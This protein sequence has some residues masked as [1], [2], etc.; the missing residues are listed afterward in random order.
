MATF[1]VYDNGFFYHG[2]K[3]AIEDIK[4]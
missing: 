4:G 1:L 2:F 3:D